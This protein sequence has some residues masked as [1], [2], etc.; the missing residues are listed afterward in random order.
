MKA[1]SRIILFAMMI[2]GFSCQEDISDC[3]N[4][5]CILAGTW[6]LTEVY[7]DDVKDVNDISQYRLVLYSP[8]PAT[9]VKSDFTRIQLSGNSDSGKWTVENN[10]TILRLIPNNDPLFTEDW[11]IESFSPRQL[12]LIINRNVSIKQG[13]GKIRF[14][15]EPL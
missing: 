13:P 8:K 11:I 4:K 7:Y 1:L 6:R 2:A 10:Q 3:P 12:I 5:L 14:V 9:E 15:L